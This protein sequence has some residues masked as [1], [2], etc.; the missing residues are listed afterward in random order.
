MGDPSATAVLEVHIDVDGHDRVRSAHDFRN[1]TDAAVAAAWPGGGVRHVAHALLTEAV[2]REAYASALAA[3]SCR[4]D[5][6]AAYAQGGEKDRAVLEAELERTVA[7]VI[8]DVVKRLARPA[9]RAIL[10]M[11]ENQISPL[12]RPGGASYTRDEGATKPPK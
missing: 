8:T 12:T 3:M 4:P 2:R 7:G 9:V 6:L 5:L 1:P 11:L 10:A